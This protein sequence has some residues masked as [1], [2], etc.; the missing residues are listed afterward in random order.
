M[1]SLLSQPELMETRRADG[2]RW[3]GPP[4]SLPPVHS[5]AE[6]PSVAGQVDFVSDGLSLPTAGYEAVA[7]VVTLLLLIRP[8]LTLTALGSHLPRKAE[9][10]NSCLRFYFLG[11]DR[12]QSSKI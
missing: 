4:S 12:L 1:N 5:Q 10:L 3:I 8:A 9:S 2:A 7:I 11:M 6:F